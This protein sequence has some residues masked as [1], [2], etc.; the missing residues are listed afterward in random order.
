[1][2]FTAA[3][4][5]WLPAGHPISGSMN[6][7]LRLSNVYFTLMK[8]SFARFVVLLRVVVV[9]IMFRT[10]TDTDMHCP[11]LPEH[12]RHQL[13]AIS[14]YSLLMNQSFYLRILN[15]IP[16]RLKLGSRTCSRLLK[17]VD[18][19]RIHHKIWIIPRPTK[20]YGSSNHNNRE[21]GLPRI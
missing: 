7:L 14:K 16:P 4:S 2:I 8:T 20:I 9:Y 15:S 11:T 3:S 19:V 13:I 17:P 10:F 5:W 6:I 18:V 12:C 21:S 1:M